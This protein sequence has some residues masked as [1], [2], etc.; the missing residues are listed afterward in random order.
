MLPNQPTLRFVTNFPT[1]QTLQ[2]L[3]DA[4]TL[5]LELKE[6]KHRQSKVSLDEAA[7]LLGVPARKVTQLVEEGHLKQAKDGQLIRYYVIR[8]LFEIK[9]AELFESIK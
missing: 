1:E 6:E 5:F 9:Q 4:H 2:L 8:V 3:L 7:D